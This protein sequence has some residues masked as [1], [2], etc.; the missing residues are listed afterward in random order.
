VS[1]SSPSLIKIREG[2]V[3]NFIFPWRFWH[4]M[5]HISFIIQNKKPYSGGAE[6]EPVCD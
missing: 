6:W 3:E 2:R 1:T 5:T 4:G